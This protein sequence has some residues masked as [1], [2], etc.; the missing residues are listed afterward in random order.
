M[1]GWLVVRRKAHAQQLA[2]CMKPCAGGVVFSKVLCF[3]VGTGCTANPPTPLSK[4]LKT[5]H[6]QHQLTGNPLYYARQ[7]LDNMDFLSYSIE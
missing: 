1:Q 3:V 4:S 7:L 6:P 5:S 2:L